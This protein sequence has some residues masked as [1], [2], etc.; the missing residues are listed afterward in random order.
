MFTLFSSIFFFLV[1]VIFKYTPLL[2]AIFFC[3]S[4]WWH[5]HHII[6][7]KYLSIYF[8][9]FFT[10]AVRASFLKKCLRKALTLCGISQHQFQSRHILKVITTWTFPLFRF[11][12][13]IGYY[14][15][16]TH[17]TK[18]TF[19]FTYYIVKCKCHFWNSRK[20]TL[21]LS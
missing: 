9:I 3:I 21:E 10:L 11:F 2:I 15:K 1:C 6:N 17:K 12:I 4:Y 16:A 14:A 13:D 7:T 8:L 5:H 19:L 18:K 20:V